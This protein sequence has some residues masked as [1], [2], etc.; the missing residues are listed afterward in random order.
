M[1][2]TVTKRML[3][4][5]VTIVIACTIAIVVAISINT[6]AMGEQNFQQCIA[7]AGGYQADTIDDKVAIRDMCVG[8][9]R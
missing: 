1:G 4:I 2:I 6:L 8:Y 5:A 7:E 3:I 9:L